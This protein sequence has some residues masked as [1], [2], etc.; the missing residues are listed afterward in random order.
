MKRTLV[1]LVGRCD[2]GAGAAGCP[3]I[4]ALIED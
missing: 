4:Q 3:I 1:E 2:I